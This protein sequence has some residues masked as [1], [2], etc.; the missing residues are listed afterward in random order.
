MNYQ[1][2][3]KEWRC[4]ICRKNPMSPIPT[5]PA[6]FSRRFRVRSS[7]CFR[8][9]VIMYSLLHP[10]KILDGVGQH[11][12]KFA[13]K[14]SQSL[15]PSVIPGAVYPHYWI[16]LGNSV[17]GWHGATIDLTASGFR[18]CIGGTIISTNIAHYGAIVLTIPVDGSRSSCN[19]TRLFPFKYLGFLEISRSDANIKLYQPHFILIILIVACLQVA[20]TD[21]DFIRWLWRICSKK[22][23]N[24]SARA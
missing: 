23:D 18:N 20:E 3:P 22:G 17:I 11:L 24:D 13:H 5:W 6:L 7:D 4:M 9:T 21:Y 1:Y 12:M 2:Q 15:P 16:A 19:I 8:E 14:Q 10:W